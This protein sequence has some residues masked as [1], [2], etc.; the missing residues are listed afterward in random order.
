MV[1]NLNINTTGTLYAKIEFGIN[2]KA[3]IGLDM[4]YVKRTYNYNYKVMDGNNGFLTYW[5][6]D[7][8]SSFSLL[9]R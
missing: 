9:L 7:T 6:E 2:A 3:G 5:E 8:Y 1:S 4:S